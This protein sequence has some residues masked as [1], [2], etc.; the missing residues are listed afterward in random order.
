MLKLQQGQVWQ[1]GTTYIRITLLER[2]SV[3]YKAMESL[4]S[5]TGKTQKAT[6][7]EFCRMIKGATLLPSA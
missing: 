3:E 5:G 7:K 4:T 6:K 1:Q 2:L